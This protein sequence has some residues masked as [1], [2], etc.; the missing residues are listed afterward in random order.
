MPNEFQVKHDELQKQ[1]EKRINRFLTITPL[2]GLSALGIFFLFRKH[3]T[4]IQQFNILMTACGLMFLSIMIFVCAG[5]VSMIKNE[6]NA[7]KYRKKDMKVGDYVSYT[8]NGDRASLAEI[9]EINGDKTK[10]VIE[11]WTSRLYP[12][13]N[14]TENGTK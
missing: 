2:I 9:L 7:T 3:F 4:D 14:P 6:M 11:V 10:I 5:I 1:H 8:S 12:T 13:Q